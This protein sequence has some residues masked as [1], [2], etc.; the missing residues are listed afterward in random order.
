MSRVQSIE[1]AFAVLGALADGPIGV[2]EVADRAGSAEVDGRAAA[3]VAGPRRRRRAGPGRHPLPARAAARDARLRGHA[4]PIAGD[5]R[6]PVARGAG[7]ATP[8]R[9]PAWRSRDGDVVHYIDQVDT[10]EPGLGP[11]LDRLADPAP[12]RVVRAGAAGLPAAD[13]RSSATRPAD[14]AVHP[15][16]DRDRRRA[17]RRGCGRSGAT[18]TPGRARSSTRASVGGGAHRGCDGEVVA[19]VHVHGPSYRFPVGR[20]EADIAELRGRRP[21]LADLRAACGTAG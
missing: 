13:V 6:P 17:A 11:R 1:R 8:A 2:T 19:A 21:R 10:P 3:R 4:R 5:A 16:D 15:A 20:D 12:R 14:G 18:A 9:R 7:R